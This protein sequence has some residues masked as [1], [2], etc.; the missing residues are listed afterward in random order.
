MRKNLLIALGTAL[1]VGLSAQTIATDNFNSLTSG[2]LATDV[3]G[4]TAGQGGYYIYGGAASDY[5]NNYRCGTW[6]FTKNN[7]WSRI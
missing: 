4:A 2:N 5:G 7:Q 1:S 3:T 6:E